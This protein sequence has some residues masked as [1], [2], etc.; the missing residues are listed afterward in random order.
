[1]IKEQRQGTGTAESSQLALQGEGG[2]S[3]ETSSP[4]PS[5]ILPLTAWHYLILPKPFYQLFKRMN[6]RVP[7][8][9]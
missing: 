7:F 8:F 9:F 2:E 6:L 3:F 5:D 1:M 4:P